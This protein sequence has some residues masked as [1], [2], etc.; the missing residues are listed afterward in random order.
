[1]VVAL[2]IL[3]ATVIVV[4]TNEDVERVR[5]IKPTHIIL[6][7]GS[8]HPKDVLFFQEVLKRFKECIPILGVCLGHQAIGLHFGARVER[9]KAIMHG[10]TSLITHNGMGIFEGVPNPVEVC[11]YHSLAIVEESIPQGTLVPTAHSEDGTIMG[12]VSQKY[13]HVVGVQFHPESYF[14]K[15]GSKMLENFLNM[16]VKEIPDYMYIFG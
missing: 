12:V 5:G 3:G 6:S 4:R 2:E 11:R 13:P 1:L 16:E 15:C 14:T 7:P 8:G 10:K 9:S